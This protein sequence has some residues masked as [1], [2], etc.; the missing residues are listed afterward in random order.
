[1]TLS[2]QGRMVNLRYVKIMSPLCPGEQESWNANR[3]VRKMSRAAGEASA[4]M[5]GRDCVGGHG[6]F[7]CREAYEDRGA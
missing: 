5:H 1:M 4:L 6:L 7:A 2:L 3:I